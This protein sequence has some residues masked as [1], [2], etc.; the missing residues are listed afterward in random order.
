MYEIE[1]NLE[2][3]RQWNLLQI[4]YI[5]FNYLKPED[6]VNPAQA[7]SFIKGVNK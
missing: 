7:Y 1:F 4:Y 3:T 5:N 2:L 6:G